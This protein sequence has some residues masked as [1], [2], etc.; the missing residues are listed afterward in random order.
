MPAAN[1]HASGSARTRRKRAHAGGHEEGGSERWLV[2]Y[3]DMLT[4]LLVLFIVLFSISVVNTSKFISLKTSLAAVFGDGRP[5]IMSGGTGLLENEANGTG[6]QLVM[7]GMP[8]AAQAGA[9]QNSTSSGNSTTTSAK[10]PQLAAMAAKAAAAN[11]K[12]DFKSIQAALHRA[13]EKAGLQK[14]VRF[15]VDHR[16]LVITVVTDDL[17]FGGNSATLLGK[18]QR[19]VQIVAP[20]LAK[21]KRSIEV[22]GYTN[23]QKV[24]TGPYPSGWELSSARASSVVRYLA[25]HGVAEDRLTAVGY[26]DQRPLYPASDPRSVT[27]NRR[28]EIVVLSTN[29]SSNDS[30]TGSN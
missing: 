1:G 24:S 20:Q 17:V 6:Q 28:V 21:E 5:G 2:T 12:S 13:L 16:G 11:E 26:S 25:S 18:G 19:I 14:A 3:A 30:T 22:D 9:N 15:S 29:P 4:L 10:D 7:P 8:V 23:Q 27:L